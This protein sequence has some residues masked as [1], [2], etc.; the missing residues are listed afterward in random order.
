MKITKRKLKEYLT[1]LAKV[2][3][4]DGIKALLPGYKEDLLNAESS[5]Y[6]Y[7]DYDEEEYKELREKF[8]SIDLN[9]LRKIS[10]EMYYESDDEGGSYACVNSLTLDFTNNKY[11]VLNYDVAEKIMDVIDTD[12]FED[13]W[14][15]N[16][17]VKEPFALKI[18]DNNETNN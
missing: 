11:V 15:L 12:A 7:N 14:E 6:K 5:L 2:E 13:N 8:E 17:N 1:Y 4:I 3:T 10:V 16:V 9:T 18:D